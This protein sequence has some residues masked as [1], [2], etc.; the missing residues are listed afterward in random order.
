MKFIKVPFLFVLS[1][2]GSRPMIRADSLPPTPGVYKTVTL[3]SGAVI[4]GINDSGQL[5]GTITDSIG[6]HGF[7]DS[8]GV[9]T[10]FDVPGSSSTQAIGVN[11]VGQIVG[12][13]T[14]PPIVDFSGHA[15]LDT[16]RVFTDLGSR[17]Q[18]GIAINNSGQVVYQTAGFIDFSIHPLLY[19]N[20]TSTGAFSFTPPPPDDAVNVEITGLNDLGAFVGSWQGGIEHHGFIDRGEL[21]CQ[22]NSSGSI[23]CSDFNFPG[24]P[25]GISNSG[26]I[27]GS[28][29]VDSGFLDKNGVFTSLA[30]SPTGINNRGQIVGGS[31]FIFTPTPEPS[32]FLLLGCGLVAMSIAMKRRR[33]SLRP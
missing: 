21:L 1:L 6:M 27:V 24:T 33:G 23:A 10:K 7:L 11:D 13:N 17:V 3:P 12:F 9:F 32:T 22:T 26:E 19:S 8:N 29:G 14:V 25:T 5:V 28:I 2:L 15:F 16:S 20:G 30:F 4:N 18:A 31:N